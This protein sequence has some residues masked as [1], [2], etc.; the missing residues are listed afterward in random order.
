MIKV[1]FFT[2]LIFTAGLN[3]KIN[4]EKIGSDKDI[5]DVEKTFNEMISYYE[6]GQIDILR[7]KLD[8]QMIGF[9][10]IIDGLTLE[11]KKCK[12]M[13][14][15][16]KDKK[17]SV[18]PDL[19]VVQTS[20]EKRCI[21]IP[22]MT[23]T[24][25]SGQSS[26]LL[27]KGLGKWSVSGIAGAS[28]FASVKIPVTI[29]ATTTTNCLAISLISVP[30]PKNFKVVVNDPNLINA[31]TVQVKV[32][33][34]SDSENVTLNAV[35]GLSG[36]FQVDTINMSKLNATPDNGTLDVAVNGTTCSTAH[37]TYISNSATNGI[38]SVSTTMQFL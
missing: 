27:H 31:K 30:I 35:S 10:N 16:F 17:T 32:T 4:K 22:S 6:S 25:D 12:Q 11:S 38:Q 14:L 26:L 21:L 24:Q 29:T 33:T 7:Q 13:R 18:G 8:P 19:A 2:V 23:A 1:L 20:W 37:I 34:G 9:Q 5:A 36:V 28:P 3:A 15:E